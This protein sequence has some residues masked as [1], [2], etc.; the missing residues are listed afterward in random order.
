MKMILAMG[1]IA[2]SLG[3]VAQTKIE[4]SI[5]V[6]SGQKVAFSF[7]YPELI[8]VHTWEKNE[9]LITGTVSI[10]RGENDDAFDFKVE[11]KNGVTQITNFL[12]DEANIPHRIIIKKGDQEYFFKA[13][14]FRDPAVQK[15][16]EENGREYQYM[17]NGILRDIKLEVFVPKGMT[18][19][20]SSTYG[21][22]E[23]TDFDGPLTVDARYGGVDATI[24]TNVTGQLVARTQFGEVLTN[25][26]VK[27]NAPEP[28]TAHDHWTEIQGNLAG[29][30]R[31]DL[32]SQ[33]GKV[34]LRRK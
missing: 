31:Y 1:L 7:D 24:A 16:L 13:R 22:V 27:F 3:V 17:S 11:N 2:C 4:R 9:V 20:I 21:M 18:C 15:F 34:Y 6:S 30:N 23:V 12:K 8:K 25:L 32:E 10:N 28:R 5:A 19:E 33:Y 26:D 14:D 29:R